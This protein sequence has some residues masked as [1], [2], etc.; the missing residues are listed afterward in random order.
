MSV[1]LPATLS[2]VVHGSIVMAALLAYRSAQSVLPPAYHVELI[3]A[4]AGERAIGAV[5]QPAAPPTAAPKP[6]PKRA[7]TAPKALPKK[8]SVK[9]APA[10]A[11]PAPDARTVRRDEPVTKAGGGPVGGQGTDVA[12]IKTEGREFPDPA[13]LNNIVRQIAVRFKPR[14]AGQ[15]HAEYVFLIRRNGSVIGIR[16]R[17]GSGSFLFDTQASGAIEAAANANAFGPLP[18][19]WADD[20]LTVI[21]TFDAQLI[22]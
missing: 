5:D 1:G 15:L 2:A 8:A 3:A 20:A 7:E 9:P 13:Y 6:P 14:N 11:T 12:N 18:A 21:F 16:L 10:K 4:P 17:Q 22:R 19:S